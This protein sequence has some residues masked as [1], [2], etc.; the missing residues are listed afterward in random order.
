LARRFLLA[1]GDRSRPGRSRSSRAIPATRPPGSWARSAT[2][3]SWSR[4]NAS[5]PGTRPP[6][7]RV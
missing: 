7:R 4:T 2:N 5:A 3:T 6:P 1:D